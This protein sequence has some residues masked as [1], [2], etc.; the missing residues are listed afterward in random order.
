MDLHDQVLEY[1]GANHFDKDIS[2]PFN[3]AR[4]LFCC[5]RY[6]DAIGNFH[7]HYH[8]HLSPCQFFVLIRDPI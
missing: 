1:G 5:H 2:G 7:Y 3:Y 6:G 4:V 8:Y